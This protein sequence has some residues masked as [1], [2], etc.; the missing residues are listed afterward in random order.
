VSLTD[1]WIAKVALVEKLPPTAT[2]ATVG[3]QLYLLVIGVLIIENDR[4]LALAHHH[5]NDA[6]PGIVRL[7][8]GSVIENRHIG[9]IHPASMP[10]VRILAHLDIARSS[11]GSPGSR[12]E[13]MVN[14]QVRPDVMGAQDC[15]ARAEEPYG[16]QVIRR[17]STNRS[18][19]RSAAGP[20]LLVPL[21]ALFVAVCAAWLIWKLS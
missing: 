16:E 18:F 19:V 21:A 1:T 10:T 4:V 13:R 17:R 2:F 20:L 7:P 9:L 8:Q 6:E 11:A 3:T 15:I 14:S 5:P 12:H